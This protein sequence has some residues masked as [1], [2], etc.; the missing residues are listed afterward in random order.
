MILIRKFLPVLIIGSLFFPGLVA[1]ATGQESMRQGDAALCKIGEIMRRVEIRYYEKE[2]SVP[3]EV[4]YYKDTEE[5]GTDRILWRAQNETGFC[6]NKMSAFVDELSGFG[7][8]CASEVDIPSDLPPD[9]M[10]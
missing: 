10:E 2:K 5:P 7:W 8:Y 3:C 1:H 9:G 6:E 4:H